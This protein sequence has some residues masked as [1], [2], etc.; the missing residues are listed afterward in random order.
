MVHDVAGYA[1]LGLTVVG[2]LCLLP[3]LNLRISFGTGRVPPDAT[4]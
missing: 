1:V 2:L 4:A 3:L